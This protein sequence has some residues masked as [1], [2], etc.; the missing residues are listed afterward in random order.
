MDQQMTATPRVVLEE[1][2]DRLSTQLAQ[3]LGEDHDPNF[4]DRGEVAAELGE[5]HALADLLRDQ[6][7][8]VERA[9]ARIDDGSYGSC[10]VCGGPIAAARLEALPSATVCIAH[11]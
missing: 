6:L 5:A 1:E 4:A 8:H 9:L 7:A 3:L 11:A 10:E 2:R